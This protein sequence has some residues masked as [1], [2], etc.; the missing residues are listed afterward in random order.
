M[1][2]LCCGH[3]LCFWA[4]LVA[5]WG[6]EGFFFPPVVKSVS[7]LLGFFPIFFGGI[8]CSQGWGF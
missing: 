7:G 1:P 6:Q 4:L 8:G 3:F 5:A 2:M